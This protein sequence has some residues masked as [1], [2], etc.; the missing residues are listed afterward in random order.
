MTED[1]RPELF[2][3]ESLRFEDEFCGRLEGR[4][5]RDILALSGK[6]T[7]YI[8]IRTEKE[9]RSALGQFYRTRNRYL[10]I[11]C[12]GNQ[13]N[14]SLTLDTMG[15]R[16]FCDLIK[17]YVRHRRVFFS[18]CEVVNRS[19]ASAMLPK[20]GCYSLIGPRKTIEFND[21]V[22]MWASFYHLMFR[23]DFDAMKGGKIRWA[24]RRIRAAFGI[25]FDYYK[26]HG[27]T[28]KKVNIDKK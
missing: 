2:V 27:N 13:R 6:R 25:Q 1:T 8:Y 16:D 28:F 12:H 26:P 17:P 20:S 7:E 19:L 9:L 18:A 3:V 11:S 22:L 10:H 23:D 21:A 5:L 4:I 15:F 24:L 14:V